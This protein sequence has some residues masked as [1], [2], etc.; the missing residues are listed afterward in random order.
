MFFIVFQ[1]FFRSLKTL[2]FF[3]FLQKVLTRVIFL[4]KKIEKR[5]KRKKLKE[6]KEEKE[7]KK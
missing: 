6:E 3:Y 5:K 2:F 1:I 4:K 7:R